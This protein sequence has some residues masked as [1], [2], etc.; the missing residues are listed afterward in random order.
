MAKK[1]KTTMRLT[2]KKVHSAHFEDRVWTLLYK[3]R[4]SHLSGA[5]GAILTINPKNESS[6]KT[7]IDVVGIDDEIAL[8][9]ECKSAERPSRLPT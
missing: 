2:R 8:G 6:P 1:N 7:Q 9:V 5:G 4:F 3:M